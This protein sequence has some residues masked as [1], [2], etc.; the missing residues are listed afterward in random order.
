MNGWSRQETK[1]LECP[2]CVFTTLLKLICPAVCKVSITLSTVQVRELSLRGKDPA[3]DHTLIAGQKLP[4]FRMHHLGGVGW[5]RG[6]IVLTNSLRHHIWLHCSWRERTPLKTRRTSKTICSGQL[7]WPFEEPTSAWRSSELRTYRRVSLTSSLGWRPK[8]EIESR[9]PGLGK[10]SLDRRSP[11]CLHKWKTS[12]LLV[13]HH[14]SLP[15]MVP[16][17]ALQA[18]HPGTVGH[19]PCGHIPKRDRVA[20]AWFLPVTSPALAPSCG[21]SKFW[22]NHAEYS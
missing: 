10:K 4:F 14:S 22:G 19:T 21:P 12:V 1:I 3:W 2:S 9:A 13:S 17:S 5:R 20:H 16:V 15:G 8:T 6:D 11:L 7:A 18:L